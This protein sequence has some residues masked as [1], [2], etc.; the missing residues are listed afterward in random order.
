MP[1]WNDRPLPAILGAGEE[2]A[3]RR[4][5]VDAALRLS[6]V[7]TPGPV[8]EL[9]A[10]ALAQAPGQADDGLELVEG[11]TSFDALLQCVSNLF[12]HSTPPIW[13]LP[14][15]EGGI[16]AFA[17]KRRTCRRAGAPGRRRRSCRPCA[18]P[19]PC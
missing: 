4:D 1:T 6:R 11:R 14:A 16:N 9:P 13:V 15:W 12:V 3:D 5:R 18:G 19:A 10:L 17:P 7:V 8:P 2:A